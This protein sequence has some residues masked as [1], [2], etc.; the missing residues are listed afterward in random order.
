MRQ[1]E[2]T[3]DAMGTTHVAAPREPIADA[4]TDWD[5]RFFGALEPHGAGAPVED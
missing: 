1:I 3:K 5:R 4:E 2:D